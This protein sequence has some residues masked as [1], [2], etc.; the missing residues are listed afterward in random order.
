MPVCRCD[1]AGSDGNDVD[2]FLF[3]KNKSWTEGLDILPFALFAGAAFTIPYAL[4]GVF[5][6]ILSFHH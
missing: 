5:P 6:K 2:S 1:D 3:G 4:T